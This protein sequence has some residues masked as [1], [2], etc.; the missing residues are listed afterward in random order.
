MDGSGW[1]WS[2][3]GGDRVANQTQLFGI[4]PERKTVGELRAWLEVHASAPWLEGYLFLRAQG[5]RHR[6]AMLATWLSL[7]TDDRGDIP[8]R[9]AFAE[10]MGVS[11]AATYTWESRRPEIRVW[12]EKLQVLRLRGS[13]LAEVDERTYEAAAGADGSAADRKLYYQRAGVWEDVERL[14]LVGAE[15]GPVEYVDVTEAELEAIR[16]ALK[17][18]GGG[19]EG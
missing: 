9:E 10:L 5:V 18:E 8:T 3:T 2:G 13:R 17:G 1:S 19:T 4:G 15:D 11:R 14:R 6:D 16:H 12:A 7:A